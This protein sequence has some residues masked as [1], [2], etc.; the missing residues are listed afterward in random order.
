MIQVVCSKCQRWEIR[1][2]HITITKSANP[3][4]EV[5]A[6]AVQKQIDLKAKKK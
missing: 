1:S 6:I 2:E 5:E 4:K 3:L